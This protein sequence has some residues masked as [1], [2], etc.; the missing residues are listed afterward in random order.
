MSFA[1]A[2]WGQLTDLT[3]QTLRVWW[4]VLPKILIAWVSGWLVYRV[5]LTLTAPIQ[6]THPWLTVAIFSCGLVTQLAAIIIAIRIA[7]QP[8]GLWETLPARAAAIGRDEPLLK[9]VSLSLLPFVGVYSVFNGINEAT[10]Q[11]FVHGALESSTV[12]NPQSATT[13]LDPT[14]ARQRLTIGAVLVASYLLRRGL[15]AAAERTG[16]WAFGL[17]GALVEGFFSVVLIFGGS[18]MLGDLGIWLRERVFYGWLLEG[19]DWLLG[20]LASLHIAIPAFLSWLWQAWTLHLWPLITDAMLAPLLWLAVTGLVFGTYTLSAAELWE[21]GRQGGF[22]GPWSRRSRRLARLESRGLSASRGSQTVVLEFVEIF[23]GDL[24]ARVI[25]FVQSLRHVLRVGLPFMG[26]FI[27]LYSLVSAM[28]PLSYLLM[29][30]LIGGN[31]FAFWFRVQPPLDLLSGMLGEPLRISL[32]AVAMTLTLS[33]VQRS[34]S[35]PAAAAHQQAQLAVPPP[36]R[37]WPSIG[38]LVSAIAL[39][40]ACILAAGALTKVSDSPADTDLRWAAP[41]ETVDLLAGQPM[42]VTGLDSGTW[43]EI[44]GTASPGLVTEAIF[45]GID[46]EMTSRARPVGSI[47]CELRA[48]G[49]DGNPLVVESPVDGHFLTPQLGFTE[50]VRVVFERPVDGLAGSRLHC[51]PMGFYLAYEPEVVFDLGI[52]E[53]L[54]TQ[55]ASNAAGMVVPDPQFEVAR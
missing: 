49:R 29:R 5:A 42:R 11:L 39:T 38:Q 25:P 16:R 32:L 1:R 46:V 43:L 35:S 17:G 52:D 3:S 48:A 34:D 19:K 45:L 21:K 41:G 44:R 50:R 54:Q 15:E 23:V 26:A 6:E 14:T 20:I 31:V 33:A 36:T 8:A 12:L 22:A 2:W 53:A 55:L 13:V 18:R 24:E 9:V 27:L 47:R 51:K 10:Y 4:Q 28:Q 7:G 30:D 40:L 37:G